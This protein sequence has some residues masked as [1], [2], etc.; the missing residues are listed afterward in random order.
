MK[1][2]RLGPAA[3]LDVREVWPLVVD[4]A[5]APAVLLDDADEAAV[6]KQRLN[7]CGSRVSWAV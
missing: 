1:S 4:D 5:D 6:A 2:S 7:A 3:S